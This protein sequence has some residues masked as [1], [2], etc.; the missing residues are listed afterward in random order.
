R[1]GQRADGVGREREGD[2]ARA[3][4][5]LALEVV[6]VERRV[7]VDVGEAD[8]EA[9][10]AREL[11]PRRHVRV[12]VELRAD[13]LVAC[14]QIAGDRAGEREAERRHVRAEHDLGRVAAE[15]ARGREP[16]AGDH[17]LAAA[18]RLEVP[19]EVR[20]RLAQVAGDRVDHL[21]RHLRPAG[22][23]EERERPPER[24]EARADG[25]APFVAH[26]TSPPLTRQVYAGFTV[27]DAPTKQSCSALASSSL[28][29][30]ASGG[31]ST[32]TSRRHSISTNANRPS[33][34]RRVTTPRA[35]PRPEPAA[36]A[37]LAW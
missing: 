13:D 30:S 14:G 19:A 5:E 12:V 21:V 7:V 8:D 23:V 18:A 1:V 6:E 31:G 34:S 26:P 27:S 33:S 24:G 16:R 37:R 15:E 22:A 10:V 35:E 11:E 2:D 29:A 4:A 9:A 25:G 36:P 20:V 3:V 32:R 28:S 17:C